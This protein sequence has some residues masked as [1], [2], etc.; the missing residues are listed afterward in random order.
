ML[1][2]PL[3]STLML[4]C[5]HTNPCSLMLLTN[6]VCAHLIAASKFKLFH[7]ILS[8]QQNKL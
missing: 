5:L 1:I 3:E 8:P 6:F 2:D 7:D 4:I